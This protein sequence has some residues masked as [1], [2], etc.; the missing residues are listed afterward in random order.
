MIVGL[1][2]G[3]ALAAPEIYTAPNYSPAGPRR[4]AL[5]LALDGALPGSEFPLTAAESDA[6]AL[7]DALIQHN[8]GFDFVVFLRGSDVSMAGVESAFTLI[9]ELALDEDDTLLVHFATHGTTCPLVPEDEGAQ[10]LR[11]V[12]TRRGEDCWEDSLRDVDLLANMLATGAGRRVLIID[13]C[14]SEFKQGAAGSS[15]GNVPVLPPL[16]EEE[17]VLRATSY[18]LDAFQMRGR[19]LYTAYLTLGIRTGQADRDGDGAI[20]ALELHDF[21]AYQVVN[22]QAAQ[23]PSSSHTAIGPVGQALVLVGTPGAPRWPVIYGLSYG[24]YPAN[25]KQFAMGDSGFGAISGGGPLVRDGRFGTVYRVYGLPRR[26]DYHDLSS[27]MPSRQRGLPSLE[28]A[29]GVASLAAPALGLELGAPV[30]V[31]LRAREQLLPELAVSAELNAWTG[32]LGLQGA[33]GYSANWT[34]WTLEPAV[35][36][37]QV[38][39]FRPEDGDGHRYSSM[40]GELS[41]RMGLDDQRGLVV[42]A[43]TDRILYLDDPP[44]N[45]ETVV[46]MDEAYRI[47]LMG[48]R[49]GFILDPWDRSRTVDHASLRPGN[50]GTSSRGE[51][52]NVRSDPPPSLSGL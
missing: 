12:E 44:T 22:A 49:V 46:Q 42:T 27:W 15:Y 51:H 26:A 35:R 5:V 45:Q 3:T 28:V 50:E 16:W 18:G 41:V 13:A 14:M 7:R 38:I 34:R 20:T 25:Q 36:A 24:Y 17:V 10:H 40:G 39:F 43:W 48:L 30:G 37:G 52:V 31:S 47:S 11:L 19:M 1:L 8:D 2:L 6:K 29:G 9:Q 4:V 33:I 32:L 21:A 23:V